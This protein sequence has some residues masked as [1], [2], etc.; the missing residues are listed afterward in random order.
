LEHYGKVRAL[1]EKIIGKS[2]ADMVFVLPDAICGV[3]IKSDADSYAR[4]ES[5]VKDYDRFF[6]VNYVVA[7]S[8]HGMHISEHVPSYWGIITV[9][10]TEAGIDFYMLREPEQKTGV[11]WPAKLS[12]L[13]RPELASLLEALGLP[14]YRERSKPFVIEK[15]TAATGVKVMEDA[16]KK[17]YL[18][19]LFERDYTAIE[20]I[21]SAF[22]KEQSLK[23]AA[24]RSV[25]SRRAVRV[26]VRRKR[27]S[28]R[29]I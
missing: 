9:E 1:E 22:K 8:S 3:E 4:L 21:I 23:K 5:Q 24:K 16:V 6:D 7:G 10:E 29:R 11:T 2:R 27:R 19:L 17:E 14:K 13:W 15:I 25:N 12:F 28:T 18:R 26:R 20:G